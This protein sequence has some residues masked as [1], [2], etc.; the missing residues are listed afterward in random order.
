MKITT[1]I[2]DKDLVSG[3]K[4]FAKVKG[5]SYWPARIELLPDEVMS[6]NKYKVIFYGT[7]EKQSRLFN[8][9]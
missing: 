5:H 9:F 3:T 2:S 7:D 4:I 6:K 1:A 8:N